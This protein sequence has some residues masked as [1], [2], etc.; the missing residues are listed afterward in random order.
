[1][2]I[3][4]VGL[5]KSEQIQRLKEE[6]EKRGHD[7]IGCYAGEL[8][9]RSNRVSFVP[10][11]RGKPFDCDLVYLWTVGKRRWEWYMVA[12]YLHEKKGIKVVNEK[13]IDRNYNYFLTPASD[14]LKQTESNILFPE[15][16]IVFDSK[17]V[18]SV[19]NMEK[20]TFPLI[21]KTAS[22]RKG[23]GVFMVKSAEEL[24]AKIDEL[25]EV[26]ASFVIREFIPNDGDVRVFTVGYKAIG[27]M[28]RTPTSKGEF[29]SNISQGGKG[30]VFDLKKYPEVKRIA[31][32]M[33]E[34]TR[35]EI[36]G[37]DIMLHKE[38][39]Q[40]YVLEINPG[41]QFKGLEQ[42]TD[43]NAAGAIIEYFER[44]VSKKE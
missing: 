13:S 14:Y 3:L 5:V 41:P 34:I 20:F 9:I 7:V 31:E 24:M 22:G 40:P 15:S 19:L 28:K 2:K 11:L 4:I 36:A 1:M 26:S 25:S 12:Q 38:T 16:A 43:V 23:K 39:G 17:G 42:Y 18:D 10:S 32:K 44:L 27:A 6:G 29:R 21:V 30:E 33:S 37:V 35:T 8:V